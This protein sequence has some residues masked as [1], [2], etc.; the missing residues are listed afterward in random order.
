MSDSPN[1]PLIPSLLYTESSTKVNDEVIEDLLVPDPSQ[2][3]AA[4][5]IMNASII[6]THMSKEDEV[7][8]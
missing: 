8:Q 3:V 7:E 1:Q 6:D 2:E 4:A 5:A